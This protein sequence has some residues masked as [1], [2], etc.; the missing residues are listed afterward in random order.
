MAVSRSEIWTERSGAR[1]SNATFV[2]THAVV[3]GRSAAP[4]LRQ[5]Q[6]TFSRCFSASSAAMH[7]VPAE[8]I[9]CR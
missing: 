7:P 5:S 1:Q 9:A 3:T 6:V 8:V 2:P 4:P